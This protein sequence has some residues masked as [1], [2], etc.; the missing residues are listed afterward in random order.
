MLPNYIKLKLHKFYGKQSD[1]GGRKMTWTGFWRS[2]LRALRTG[3]VVYGVS[4][5]AVIIA[6]FPKLDYWY[7]AT[8]CGIIA[9]IFK[10][11]REKYPY[12]WLWKY[13][14]L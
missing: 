14:P 3:L 4:V 7:I 6:D 5:V 9:G 13:L 8:A 11:L 12:S 2:I 10:G 1:K